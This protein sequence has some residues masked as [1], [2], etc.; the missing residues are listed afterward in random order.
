MLLIP[1]VFFSALI[2]P[3]GC[4]GGVKPLVKKYKIHFAVGRQ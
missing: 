3:N 1:Q 4:E 2:P